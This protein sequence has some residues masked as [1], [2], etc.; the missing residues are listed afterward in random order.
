MN[1]GYIGLGA[2][3]SALARRLLGTHTLSV[4]DINNAAVASFEKLGAS[5]APFSGRPRAPKRYRAA[6]PATQF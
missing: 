6:V 3:G 1:I 4:W 5:V 2:M